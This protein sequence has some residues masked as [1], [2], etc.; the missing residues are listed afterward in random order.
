V[1][2]VGLLAVRRLARTLRWRVLAAGFREDQHH[3]DDDD[4]EDQEPGEEDERADDAQ[5]VLPGMSVR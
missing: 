2:R 1:A 3:H 4:R 5:G